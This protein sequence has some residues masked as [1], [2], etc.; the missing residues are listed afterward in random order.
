MNKFLTVSQLNNYIKNVF[1]DEMLLQNITVEGEVFEAKFSG[2]NTYITLREG[3]YSLYCVKFG[4]RL[5]F[6]A[7]DK[8]RAYGSMRF[9]PKGG[10]AT[11]V[12]LSASAVGKGEL[13]ARLDELKERLH[14]EGIFDNKKPL[15]RIIRRVAIVTSVDGA[16][17][18]DFMD[19]LFRGGCSYVDVDVYGVKVQG[20]N[21]ER[22]ISRAISLASQKNYDVLVVARGGGSNQDLSC[23]NAECVAKSVFFCPFASI[24]AIGHQVDYT[25]CDFSASIRAGTPSIAAELIVRNNEAYISDFYDCIGRLKLSAENKLGSALSLIGR[26]ISDMELSCEK[27]V[28]MMRAKLIDCNNAMYF[29]MTERLQ[30]ANSAAVTRLLQLKNGVEAKV[31]GMENAIKLASAVLDRASPLKIISDG[32]AKILKDG[33]GIGSTK[34][35]SVGDK[36][37]VLLKDGV[38]TVEVEQKEDKWT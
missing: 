13:L 16:V 15:P 8:I 33:A 20:A 27:R 32:Y 2:G 26:L 37:K 3:E 12:V 29:G 4:A 36:L 6:P 17:I 14:K 34:E 11:F 18:H 31:S 1:D 23:F 9:Y 28:S 22:T 19:V 24:S 21:A 5:D 35:V 10:K 30:K 25:L 38:L 7:G